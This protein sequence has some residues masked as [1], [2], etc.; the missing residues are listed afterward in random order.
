[1]IQQM[2]NFLYRHPRSA[3]MRYSRFGGYFSYRRMLYKSA[4]M[5]KASAKLEPVNSYADGLPLYFLTG[6]KYLYQTLF[7]IRSL[8]NCSNQKFRFVLVDDG[9]FNQDMINQVN[10]QLPGAEIMTGQLI[11]K[12]L[13][14]KLSKSEYPVLNKKRIE[15]PHIKKLTDIHTLPGDDWKVVL[16]SDMLFWEEPVAL[17]DWLRSPDKPGHMVDCAESYGYSRPLME[18][19]AGAQVPPL[20]NV[21]IIGL[22]SNSINWQQLEKWIPVLEEKEGKSYYLEQAL[23]AMLIGD[24]KCLVLEKTEF[25]VNPGIDEVVNTT[26]IL[27]HYVDLSKKGYFNVAWQKVIQ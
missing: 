25:I 26:G 18:E 4:L 13:E 22:N 17:I 24:K 8:A 15:Y 14:S 20:L 12:N 23:S 3:L 5:K 2:I 27:H 19:L 6:R 10:K 9:S 16:D 1:M 11:E 21:G 7:C